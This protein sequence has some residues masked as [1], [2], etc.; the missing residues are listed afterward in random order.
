LALSSCYYLK[1]SETGIS[2]N[3]N[4]F[5]HTWHSTDHG[6]AEHAALVTEGASCNRNFHCLTPNGVSSAL[7][8]LATSFTLPG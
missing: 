7:C 6:R 4:F 1:H 2:Q 5:R 3:V 8:Q